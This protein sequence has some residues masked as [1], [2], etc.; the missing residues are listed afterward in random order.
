VT[1]NLQTVTGW[2][3][4]EERRNMEIDKDVLLSRKKIRIVN[5]EGSKR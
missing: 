3:A 1:N 5:M 4:V 2:S